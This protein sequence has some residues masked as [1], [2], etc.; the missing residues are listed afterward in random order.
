MSDQ[1]AQI[2]TLMTRVA[3]AGGEPA[4]SESILGL[5]TQS[6][7]ESIAGTDSTSIT[8]KTDGSYQTLAPTDGLSLS[9]DKLQYALNE[10]PCID[11]AGGQSLIRTG[12][13]ATDQRWPGYGRQATA[14]VGV[15]SQMAFEMYSGDKN[16]GGL[17][18][19]SRSPGA[20][21]DEESVSL[22]QLFASQAASVM[23]KA[24]TITQYTQALT[25]RKVI[26]QA[27]GL[28]MAKYE[29]DED[30]AFQFMVR[31]SS[32]AN[33]KLRNVAQQIVDSANGRAAT[34]SGSS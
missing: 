30:R 17:N 20:F 2:L 25:S 4:D 22:A 12:D 31:M 21:N 8:T 14:E 34:S 19:Y 9:A 29:L 23:G 16:Y 15:V 33:I 6:A 7:R 3:Q 18:L 13:L 28:L 1:Q 11:A 24:A 26:G 27:T 32:T 10:G 5:I